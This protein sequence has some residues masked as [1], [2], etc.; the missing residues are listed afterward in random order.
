M[1]TPRHNGKIEMTRMDYHWSMPS[2]V[3]TPESI[4]M[5]EKHQHATAAGGVIRVDGEF[6]PV[7]RD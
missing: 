1:V 2:I 4:P 6:Y 3:N 7:R 5:C